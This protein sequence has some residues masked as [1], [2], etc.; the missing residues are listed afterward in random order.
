[1]RLSAWLHWALAAYLW[2]VSCVSLGNW[3]AQAEP[4]FIALLRAGHKLEFGDVGFFAFVTLPAILFWIAYR[5]RSLW[6]ALAALSFDVVWLVMQVQSWWLPYLLGTTKAWQLAYAQGPTTKV[7]PSFG[8]HVA[9]DGMHFL[10]SVLLVAGMVT[11]VSGLRQMR[12][13]K[14]SM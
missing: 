13:S 7:L 4:H 9:P 10:I 12:G 8:A 14:R 2:L 3:N 6:F 1:M 11:A 5:R